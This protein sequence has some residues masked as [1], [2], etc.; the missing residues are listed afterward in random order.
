VEELLLAAARLAPVG[1]LRPLTIQTV[2]G[3][4]ASTGLRPTEALR[5]TRDDVDLDANVLTIRKTKFRKS[6]LVPIHSTV[7]SVLLRYAQKRDQI[8]GNTSEPVFFVLADGKPLSAKKLETAFHRIAHALPWMRP[9]IHRPARLYDL[10]HTF[11]CRRLLR[12]YSEGT[13]VQNAL[14]ALSTY[15]GHVKVTSTYWYLTGT[16]ELMALAGGRFEQFAGHGQ[17][18]LT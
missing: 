17:G 12:W 15:L 18:G 4:L 5:L 2:L 1:G 6:R 7:A 14:P 13:D 8:V 3:L 9:P 11:A 16:T 10:R